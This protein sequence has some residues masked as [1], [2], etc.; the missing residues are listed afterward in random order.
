MVKE[1][2]EQQYEE[3]KSEPVGRAGGE[4]AQEV[5]EAVLPDVKDSQRALLDCRDTKFDK[6]RKK[7][8]NEDGKAELKPQMLLVNN[9]CGEQSSNDV[10]DGARHVYYKCYGGFLKFWLLRPNIGFYIKFIASVV[11]VLNIHRQQLE[12]LS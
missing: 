12:I 10:R 8:A 6:V 11:K 3:A 5:K 1:G 7:V 9:C 2:C 4:L